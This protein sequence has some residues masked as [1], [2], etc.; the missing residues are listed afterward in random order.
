[1]DDCFRSSPHVA[2]EV[3]PSESGWVARCDVT[4]AD[5]GEHWTASVQI[6]QDRHPSANLFIDLG[7][8]RRL[9]RGTILHL[10]F[11]SPGEG[12]VRPR[13]AFVICAWPESEDL[14]IAHC[15][16]DSELSPDE[17]KT[18]LLARGAEFA[19][20]SSRFLLQP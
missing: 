8:D 11:L 9:E 12:V 15:A 1:M 6:S 13:H 5:S 19:G 4:E 16:L 7:V 10:R 14:F 17:R 3:G 20:P 2:D 18:L